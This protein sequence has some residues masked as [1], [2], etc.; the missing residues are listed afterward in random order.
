MAA[1]REL[2][3]EYRAAIDLDICF[4]D[5][6]D[7]LAALPGYYAPPG[8][9]LFVAEDGGK[10]AGVLGI[11]PVDVAAA[12]KNR[13]EIK[14]LYV[15]APWRRLGLGRQLAVRAI[16]AARA[17]GYDILCLETLDFMAEARTLYRSLGFAEIPTY[18][19]SA[20]DGAAYKEH[21][22]VYMERLL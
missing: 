11:R 10:T 19:D 2:F 13:A 14:R 16:E 7:E 18:Y 4:P 12:G 9:A 6:D 3:E 8:G 20:P 15:R 5:F 17:A 1:V 22:V 21:G